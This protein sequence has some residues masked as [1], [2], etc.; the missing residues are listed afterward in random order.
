[1]KLLVDN[2]VFSELSGGYIK[3]HIEVPIFKGDI[4]KHLAYKYAVVRAN[5]HTDWEL[6]ILFKAKHKHLQHG[7]HVNRFLFLQNVYQNDLKGEH[8]QCCF[9]IK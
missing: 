5:N 4:N 7:D 3:M 2:I 8:L 1:M 6:E 9:R